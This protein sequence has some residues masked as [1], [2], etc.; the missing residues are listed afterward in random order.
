MGEAEVIALH[1]ARSCFNCTLLEERGMHDDEDPA[2]GLASWC[3]MFREW[4]DSE[5]HAASDCPTYAPLHG[6]RTAGGPLRAAGWGR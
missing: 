5:T 3:T 4:I 2:A 6:P 1:P